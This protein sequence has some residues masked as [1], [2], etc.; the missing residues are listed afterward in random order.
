MTKLI[1]AN[2]AAASVAVGGAALLLKMHQDG[3]APT[4]AGI[5]NYAS[6][7]AKTAYSKI[8]NLF[9]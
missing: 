8:T 2:V 6:D 9:K 4:A 1:V 7:S 3:V 5:A